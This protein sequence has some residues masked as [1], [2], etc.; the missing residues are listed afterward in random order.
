MVPEVG[1]APTSPRLQRGANLPQLLGVKWKE[2]LRCQSA[3]SLFID[4]IQEREVAHRVGFV[5]GIHHHPMPARQMDGGMIRVAN[6]ST[7]EHAGVAA[8][9]APRQ[10]GHVRPTRDEAL[11]SG[12]SHGRPM[13]LRDVH[14]LAAIAVEFLH[15]V[16]LARASADGIVAQDEPFVHAQSRLWHEEPFALAAKRIVLAP[17]TLARPNGLAAQRIANDP[18][19]QCV[20]GLADRGSVSWHG[21][22]EPFTLVMAAEERSFF[23]APLRTSNSKCRSRALV[24]RTVR[25]TEPRTRS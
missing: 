7:R 10:A 25:S 22:N 3:S 8:H 9:D 18:W 15:D 14:D 24:W 6:R 5:L 16:G 23:S 13:L 21:G 17:V 11:V 19:L 1:I 4:L 20:L 12:R 2:A